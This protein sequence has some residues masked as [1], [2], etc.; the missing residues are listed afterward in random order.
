MKALK[1]L[2][3]IAALVAWARPTH[4][5]DYSHAAVQRSTVNVT[6]IG[7]TQI[8]PSQGASEG[9]EV[10]DFWVFC[11]TGAAAGE[12]ISFVSSNTITS[13]VMVTSTMTVVNGYLH[14][15]FD[16]LGSVFTPAGQPLG[17]NLGTPVGQT[18]GVNV[19]WLPYP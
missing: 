17:M 14:S 13:G 4:A 10:L 1:R 18:C 2:C 19:E 16:P 11:G 7:V 12:Q 15:G 5:T 9:I 6:S 3:L 8:V